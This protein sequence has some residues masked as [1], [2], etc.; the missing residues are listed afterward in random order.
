M[1]C[2]LIDVGSTSLKSAVYD[3]Q[4]SEKG[5]VRKCPFPAPLRNEPPF[6]E[7]DAGAILAA[8]RAMIDAVLPL[9]AICFSVQMHGYLLG[10]ASG[11][12]VTPYISWQDERSLCL[13]ENR[14]YPFA[15]PA[16]RGVSKKPNLPLAGLHMMRS[17]Q[18]EL[19]RRAARVYS[20]GSFIAHALTGRNAA[21]ITDLAPIGAYDAHSGALEEAGLPPLA[22]PQALTSFEPVG[23]YR[24]A[25]VYAPVG[26]QQASALGSGLHPS[27]YLLNL[28]TA[29]QVCAISGQPVYG[30]FESR[31]YFDGQTLCTV[32]RLTGGRSI[33]ERFSE[34]GFDEALASEYGAALTRLPVRTK[35]LA[36]G[37]VCTYFPELIR[38]V[39]D[40]IGIEYAMRPEADAL[41]GLIQLIRRE[42]P[43]NVR[44]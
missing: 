8:V 31:P 23:T 29:T 13:P 17:G 33:V 25:R 6:F 40:R 3:T 24:G 28:G 19:F 5:N 44:L 22:F 4:S 11:R 42:C 14:R 39:L 35:L 18:P 38:A 34:V 10:D 21:H 12:A 26:D 2:L 30:E 1:M 32:T 16:G 43:H 7:V 20:L 9:D 37:G 36:V 41:D 15:L 27:E